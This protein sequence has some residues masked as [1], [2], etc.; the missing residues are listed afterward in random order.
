MKEYRPDVQY[1]LLAIDYV[2]EN[3]PSRFHGLMKRLEKDLQGDWKP[4]PTT[5]F[6]GLHEGVAAL[7]FLQ[8]AQQIGKVILTV[9]PRMGL[10]REASYMLSGGM[11]ALGIVTAQAM[12]E[13][14]ARSLM[15]LSRSG[16]PATEVLVQWEWLQNSCVEVMALKC[17]V[18]NSSSVK[19]LQG[20]IDSKQTAFPVHGVLHLAGV[21]DDGM[22]P[23]LSRANLEA[24]FGPKV[25]GAHYLHTLLKACPL[26]FFVLYS[27][28]A[29]LLGAAGQANY[30]AA[31]ASLDGLAHHWRLSG[32]PATSVQWGPWLSVGMAWHRTIR[33]VA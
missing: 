22:I 9:P 2:M 7:Q 28:T 32:L 30:S 20:E 13:E 10:A 4:L 6:E 31:N 8:R 1:H 21:L 27:S 18:G 17:D 5:A 12:V 15:L 29:A 3:E 16:K 19:T 26:D 24:S 11:G 23:Q 25:N 14:G 33:S